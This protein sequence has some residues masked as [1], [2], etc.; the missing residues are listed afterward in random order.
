MQ[1]GQPSVDEGNTTG[2]ELVAIVI[3]IVAMAGR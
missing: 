3:V 1:L 2:E